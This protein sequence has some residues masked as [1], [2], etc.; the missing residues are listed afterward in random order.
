MAAVRFKRCF[1][2]FFVLGEDH[3]AARETNASKGF[4]PLWGFVQES[5]TVMAMNYRCKTERAKSQPSAEIQIVKDNL[6]GS[7]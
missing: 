4:F 3:A 6:S 2:F 5:N 7:M 1:F